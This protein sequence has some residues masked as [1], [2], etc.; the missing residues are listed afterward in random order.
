[1]KL[2]RDLS[3]DHLIRVL[4]QRWEYR[5]VHQ[6]G[7][8]VLLETNAPSRQRVVVP[9]HKR[10]RVGTLNATLRTIAAHKAVTKE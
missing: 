4:C 2:P 8:H 9:A 5:S 1:M 7:S 6:V 10:L 3:G